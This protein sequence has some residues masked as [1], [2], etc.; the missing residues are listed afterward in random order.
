[1]KRLTLILGLLAGPL[2]AQSPLPFDVGGPF[3]LTDQ[4]GEMRTEA[5]PDGQPQLLFFGYANCPG[6]CSAALPLMADV[7]D[8]V[9][10]AGHDLRPV[11]IT[12][13]PERDRVGTMQAPLAEHH[14]AFIGLTGSKEALAT[15]YAAFS[16]DHALA[17][18]DPKYGPV[19]T[20]GSLIYLLDGSGDV[21]TLIPPVLDAASAAQIALRYMAPES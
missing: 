6:I 3:A 16:V 7:T 9:A 12:V 18:E 2:L 14:P 11:M 13:D 20:H 17:Y 4:N 1:M 10:E 15:A 8:L 19:F 21:L 5:D